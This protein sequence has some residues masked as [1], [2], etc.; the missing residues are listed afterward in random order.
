MRLSVEER[1][2]TLAEA[3]ARDLR[4]H[5][6]WPTTLYRELATLADGEERRVVIAT[7]SGKAV[8]LMAFQRE[9]GGLNWTPVTQWVIPDFVGLGEPAIQEEMLRRLPFRSKIAWWRASAPV[10]EVGGR[11]WHVDTESTYGTLLSADFEAHWKSTDCA[12]TIRRAERRSGALPLTI[13]APGA[14]EWVIRNCERKWRADASAELPRTQ[15]RLLAA[16][17]LEQL[18]KFFTLTLSSDGD[19]A[20]GQNI[21]L[22]RRE[23]V[24][25][26]TYRAPQFDHLGV[27]NALLARVYRWGREQGYTA[28]DIGGGFS[29]KDDWSPPRG[30]KSYVQ[31]SPLLDRVR[32]RY[33]GRVLSACRALVRRARTLMSTRSEKLSG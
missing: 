15:H 12:R 4:E 28:I 8:G 27:G 24:C 20:A 19:L 5:P 33:G 25:I 16:R 14:A 30:T 3:A 21:L 18:G 23:L 9:R 26:D 29:Y 31:I 2:S 11:I 1:W 7:D 10:P 13:N 6:E 17:H 22:H 32:A